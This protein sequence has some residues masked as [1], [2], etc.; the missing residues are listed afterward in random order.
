MDESSARRGAWGL[1][2]RVIGVRLAACSWAHIPPS[3]HP[4]GSSR[5]SRRPIS[6]LRRSEPEA[7]KEALLRL[8][9]QRRRDLDVVLEAGPAQLRP[10]QIV[11][12]EEAGGVV[13]LDLD[14]HLAVLA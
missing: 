6:P 2:F 4:A 13:H 3:D 9:L 8:A 10:Q 11:H 1:R 7:G 12:L 5:Q 14:Q